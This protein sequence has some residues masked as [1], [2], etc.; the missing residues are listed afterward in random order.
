MQLQLGIDFFFFFFAIFAQYK[1]RIGSCT[2]AFTK[3]MPSG[4]LHLDGI[5]SI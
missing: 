5:L 4:E 2:R 3:L 1:V